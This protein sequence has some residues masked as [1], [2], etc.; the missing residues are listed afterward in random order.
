[1]D[2]CV[3]Q[4]VCRFFFFLFKLGLT[5]VVI[6]IITAQIWKKHKSGY[7]F[8]PYVSVN[9]STEYYIMKYSLSGSR[10][11]YYS[12]EFFKTFFSPYHVYHYH[13]TKHVRVLVSHY[14]TCTNTIKYCKYYSLLS[15]YWTS[16]MFCWLVGGNLKIFIC[17][18]PNLFHLDDRKSLYI[19]KQWNNILV[20]I[21]SIFFFCILTHGKQF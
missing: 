10:P 16:G 14:K 4:S 18:F 5:N 6:L 12:T 9:C 1:M 20:Y 17:C 19:F 2:S 13:T 7:C 8:S 11:L 15:G 3:V 21:L